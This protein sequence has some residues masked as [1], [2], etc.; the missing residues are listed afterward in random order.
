MRYAAGR[1]GEAAGIPETLQV[2]D[3][4]RN[5]E[6]PLNEHVSLSGIGWIDSL[7]HVQLH[8]TDNSL[9]WTV[10]GEEGYWPVSGHILMQLADGWSP[11]YTHAEKLPDGIYFVR[12]GDGE[13]YGEWEEY[14][15]PCDPAEVQ[16]GRLEAEITLNDTVETLE[17]SW[18][19]EV[20]L[21]LIQTE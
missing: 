1:N 5:T 20:P 6:I 19:V 18:A 11:L 15:F 14:I 4:T 21:R 7:L 2:L 9:V 17:G 10:P 3:Y 8:Y 12:M 13:V 16:A